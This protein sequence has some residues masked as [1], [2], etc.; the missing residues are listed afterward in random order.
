MRTND[1]LEIIGIP[2][3]SV[4]EDKG[5][6]GHIARAVAM[7]CVWEKA[8]LMDRMVCSSRLSGANSS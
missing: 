3:P 8:F 1:K 5:D 6:T 7:C 4:P 2:V